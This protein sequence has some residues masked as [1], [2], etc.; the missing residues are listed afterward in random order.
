MLMLVV[1]HFR[2]ILVLTALL[3]GLFW[4]RVLGGW[5]RKDGRLESSRRQVAEVHFL[6]GEHWSS[7]L[8]FG[9]V[10]LVF[11]RRQRKKK[12]AAVQ[13]KTLRLLFLCTAVG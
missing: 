10:C 13:G 8:S 3:T 4:K 6:L 7:L 11:L 1:G 9:L 2:F 5:Q 12:M